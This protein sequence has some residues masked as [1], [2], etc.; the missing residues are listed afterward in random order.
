MAYRYNKL[1]KL[2]ID[3]EM[4]KVNLRDAAGITSATLAKL[5]K[6]QNV[7]MEVLGRICKVLECDVGDVV[8]YV[9]E[10]KEEFLHEQ[11]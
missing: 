1:W 5:S 11:R 4:N 3:K 2:L 8:E 7:S 9:D 10:T 6:N